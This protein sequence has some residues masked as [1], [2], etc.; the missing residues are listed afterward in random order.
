MNE[1]VLL[2]ELP[3][4]AAANAPDAVALSHAGNALD[5][6]T[7]AS[8]I[9]SC[10][11]ALCALGLRRGERVGIYLDKRPETVLAAFAAAA[12][13]GAFVPINPILKAAQVG[14][15]LQDCNV[16][17]LVTSPERLALLR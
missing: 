15:I 10:A 12:A 16:R 3:Y 8:R 4:R 9:E 14:Y 17:V 5:Y 7:V 2:H 13:G 11:G 6:A 1:A